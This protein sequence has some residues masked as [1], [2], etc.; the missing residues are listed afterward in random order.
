MTDK[1]KGQKQFIF[2]ALIAL[3]LLVIVSIFFYADTVL[4][5]IFWIALIVVIVLIFWKGEMLLMLEEFERVVISRY[6]RVNRV[7]GPG[8]TLLIPGIESYAK[9]DLRTKTIDVPKQDVITKDS[10]EIRIDAVLYLRVKKGVQDIINSVIEIEDYKN[11]SRLFIIAALR[12]KIGN[13][14]LADVISNVNTLN[15]EL[16]SELKMLTE[17]WGIDVVD[18]ELKDVDVPKVIIDAMHAEKAAI[19]E[20]LARIEK[21]KAHKEEILA[22]K[23]AAENLTPS[24]LS[25]YYVKALEQMAQGKSTKLIF[26]ME[27]S[28]LVSSFS[29]K[30]SPKEQDDF[31]KTIAPYKALIE[32]YVDNAVKKAKSKEKGKEIKLY[33]K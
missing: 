29:E 8:W 25:Y 12:N 9:V 32:N 30:L 26:P 11:A 16:E 23:E 6:G 20:K 1:E 17:K 4:Q 33:E 14:T 27:I 5:N 22:V 15:D 10:I 18:I 3:I 21:A 7:G 31:E 19:Q 24:T 2:I 13:M 28:K